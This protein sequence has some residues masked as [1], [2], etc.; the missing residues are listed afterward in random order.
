MHGR[1]AGDEEVARYMGLYDKCAK[2]DRHIGELK[3]MLQTVLLRSDALFRAEMGAQSDDASGRWLTPGE[4]ARAVRLAFCGRASRR[5]PRTL[6]GYLT[7]RKSRSRAS[8][9][10]SVSTLTTSAPP[11][12]SKT[13]PQTESNMS[14]PSS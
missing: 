3:S 7:I 8:S 12:S 2:D 6:G 5:P 13:S 14:P 4:L 10:S 9:N 11:M 1:A